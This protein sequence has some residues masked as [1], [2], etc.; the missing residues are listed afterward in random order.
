MNVVVFNS[1]NIFFLNSKGFLKINMDII[2]DIAAKRHKIHKQC[3]L[4]RV[5]SVGYEYQKL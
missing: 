3:N 2:L 4:H 1:R 5:I